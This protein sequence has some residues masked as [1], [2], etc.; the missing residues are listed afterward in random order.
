[1]LI[2][3]QGDPS[4]EVID[5]RVAVYRFSCVNCGCIFRE[6]GTECEAIPMRSC[7]GKVVEILFFHACP[8]CRESVPGER[9]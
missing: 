5:P 4:K 6:Q 7:E 8:N 9:K 3:K 2:E 1:M